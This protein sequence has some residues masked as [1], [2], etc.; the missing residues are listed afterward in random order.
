MKLAEGL[1]AAG[2]GVRILV[3]AAKAAQMTLRHGNFGSRDE[4]E[5]ARR[6]PSRMGVLTEVVQVR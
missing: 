5:S 6:E 1:R 4:A 3:K 2:H